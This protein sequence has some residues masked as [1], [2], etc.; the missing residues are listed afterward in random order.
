MSYDFSSTKK[1]ME[2]ALN[3]FKTELSGLRTG[4]ASAS[5][6][7]NVMVEAY[8]GRVPL[9]QVAGVSVPEPR[10]LVVQAWDSTV[11]KAI[12]KGITNAGLGLNPMT[13]GQS[14]RVPIPELSQERRVELVKAAGRCAENCKVAIRN[15]RRDGMDDFKKQE[16]DNKMSKDEHKKYSDELQ[17]ITDDFVKK[18]DESFAAKEKDILQ[19]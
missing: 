13:D 1:R 10:M 4:R 11:L 14:I 19:N 12:E 17:K 18:V 8:G 2:G 9:N 16:K 5:L 3:T 7:E 15:V 6:L